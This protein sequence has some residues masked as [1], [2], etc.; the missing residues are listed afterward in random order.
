MADSTRKGD[1]KS[2]DELGPVV[3][4]AEDFSR[5][6][7]NESGTAQPTPPVYQTHLE[8]ENSEREATRLREERKHHEECGS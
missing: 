2:P 3:S 6:L 8:R 1:A 5:D 4:N 7:R